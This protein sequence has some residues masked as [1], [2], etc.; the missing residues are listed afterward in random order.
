[1]VGLV[2]LYCFSSF[3]MGSDSANPQIQLAQTK[4]EFK[5]V[6][7]SLW[8]PLVP[9]LETQPPHGVSGWMRRKSKGRQS[10]MHLSVSC[11]QLCSEVVQSMLLKSKYRIDW[12]LDVIG[13]CL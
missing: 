8:I 5:C 10:I 11:S 1:M 2:H 4:C 7:K 13:G 3:V 12:E 9:L 6:P